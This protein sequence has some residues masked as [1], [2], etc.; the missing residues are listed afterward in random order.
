[1]IAP[2]CN[3]ARSTRRTGN[4]ELCVVHWLHDV[5]KTLKKE[6]ERKQKKRKEEKRKELGGNR[7]E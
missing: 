1:L 6:K 2:L 5:R 7:R 4:T 3:K